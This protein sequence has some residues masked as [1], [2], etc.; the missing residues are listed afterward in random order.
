[1]RI[2]DGDSKLEHIFFFFLSFSF[3]FLQ[4]SLPAYLC[5]RRMEK[6]GAC[7]KGK[8]KKAKRKNSREKNLFHKNKIKVK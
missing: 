4:L 3:F 8:G 2:L 7:E 5:L 1:M 6:G